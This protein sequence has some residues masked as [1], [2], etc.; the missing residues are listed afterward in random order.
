VILLGLA[1]AGMMFSHLFAVFYLAPFGAAELLRLYRRRKPDVALWAALL[2]PACFPFIY[3]SLVAKFESSVFPESF[4]AS[5]H[6]I[7]TFY[8]VT[9]KPEGPML[10]M[11]LFLGL[12]L[13]FRRDRVRVSPKALPDSLEAAFIAG[14]LAIPVAINIVLMRSHGA[15]FDRYGGPAAIGLA[16]A[17]VFLIAAYTNVSRLAA[18]TA[19]GVLLLYIPLENVL[20]TGAQ[21]LHR[22]PATAAAPLDAVEPALPL[23]AASGLTFLEMDK[24]ASPATVGRLHYLTDT[25]LAVQYAHANIFEGFPVLKRYFPIRAAVD[26]FHKFIRLHPAFLVLGTPGYPEDWLLRKLMADGDELQ[27]L[28]DFPGPYKDTSLYRITVNSR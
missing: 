12:L 15:F 18:L 7:W 20:S 1:V 10:L 21:L 23:V 13:A 11:A 26:P 22:H 25:Q 24:Y 28:G 3:L 2:L 19:A 16:L 14:A 9:L 4:Q 5:L 27:Y 17:F 8:I 6:R